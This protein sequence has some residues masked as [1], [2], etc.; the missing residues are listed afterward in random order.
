MAAGDSLTVN[1]GGSISVTTSAA[2][3]VSGGITV[4]AIEN[5]GTLETSGPDHVDEDVAGIWIHGSTLNGGIT[6]NSGGIIRSTTD[7]NDDDHGAG[8]FI[9]NS[10]VSGGITNRGTISSAGDA[11]AIAIWGDGTAGATGILNGGITNYG[12]ISSTGTE[13]MDLDDAATINGGIYNY[14]TISSTVSNAIEV[15]ED[16][17]VNGGITNTGTIESSSESFRIADGSTLADGVTNSGTIESTSSDV[18]F[19]RDDATLSGGI[20]NTGTIIASDDV[21]DLWNDASSLTG[22]VKNYGTMIA[23]DAL[24]ATESSTLSGGVTNYEGGVMAGRLRMRANGVTF[25]NNGLLAL[26]TGATQGKEETTGTIAASELNGTYVQ[27]STGTLN[28]GVDSNAS[29]ST[30]AVTGDVT[31]PDNAKISLDVKNSGNNI[32]NGD[33]FNNVISATGTLTASSF[34]VTDNIMSLNFTAVDDGS[35]NVDITATSTGMTTVAAATSSSAGGAAA[36]FDD[37]LT[38]GTTDDD[39]SSVASELASLGSSGEVSD[40]VEQTV[41][42]LTG[43]MQTALSNAS[44]GINKI[45][46]ARLGGNTGLSTGDDFVI[47]GKAWFKPFA[48]WAEQGNRDG[49]A[50]YDVNTV[51]SVV[52][53]DTEMSDELRLGVAFAF[54]HSQVKSKSDT[55]QN[56][57]SNLY[58]LVGYGSY[59]LDTSTE[60]SFQLDA[61]VTKNN[62]TRHVSFGAIDR[63]AH[64]NYNTRAVH[65]GVGIGR[66]FNLADGHILS[67]SVRTDYSWTQDQAYTETG[68][69]SLNLIVDRNTGSNFVLATDVKYGVDITDGQKL[70]LNAGVGYDFMAGRNTVTAAYQGAPSASFKTEG[71]TVPEWSYSAGVGYQMSCGTDC[72]LNLRYDAQAREDFLSNTVS[73]KFRW[74]F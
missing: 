21:I 12:T 25:T 42:I 37:V 53:A 13:A 63:D 59:A 5:S 66:T 62:G 52:G 16:T 50:G 35:G 9:N 70:L 6:N 47:S 30:L 10:T 29:F 22:G 7:T 19:I 23:G 56:A 26:K 17:V 60:V 36:V 68:A 67:P 3:K 45:V 11:G 58:Q 48:T 39:F 38:N 8:I 72:E 41:P 74:S 54:A 33:S 57:I 4:N 55:P 31:L 34:N 40:A 2:V 71:M 44:G 15:D 18:F 28:L 32:N 69:G 61:G 1:S 24:I 43:G 51:G 65:G 46:Q 14:G 49:V 64:A 20:T 27:G 73:A